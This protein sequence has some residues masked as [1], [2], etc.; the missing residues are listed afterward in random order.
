MMMRELLVKKNVLIENGILKGYLYDL[1]TAKQEGLSSTGN[2]RRESYQNRPIP[3][4]MT[5]TYIAPGKTDAEK[6]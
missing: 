6:K 3:P 2:G 1:K 4:R 5:N